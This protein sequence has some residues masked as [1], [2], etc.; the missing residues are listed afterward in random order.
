MTAATQNRE[1]RWG[2][3]GGRREQPDRTQSAVPAAKGDAE[4][5]SPGKVKRR[6]LSAKK[7]VILA[8]AVLALG[9][10]GYMFLAPA[11]AGPVTGGEVVTLEATTLNLSGG[12]YL[13]IAVAIQLV[14][15][16]ASAADFASSHAAELTIDEFSNRTVA[17]LASNTARKRLSADLLTKIKTAYPKE[18]YDVFLTQFVT[19]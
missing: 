14:K 2:S 9:G 11:K 10:G 18:V 6:R 5:S 3:S 16:K 19:Q 7:L 15:G 4:P 1:T 17:S 8:V 12:H 13:K